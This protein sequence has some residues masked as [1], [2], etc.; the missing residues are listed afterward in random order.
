MPINLLQGGGLEAK[1]SGGEK[2]LKCHFLLPGNE[3]R[4]GKERRSLAHL[5]IRLPES[6][7]SSGERSLSL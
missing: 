2:T 6:T 1:P 3:G 4:I 7:D 5:F